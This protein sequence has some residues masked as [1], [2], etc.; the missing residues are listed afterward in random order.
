MYKTAIFDL[1][2]TLLDTLDDLTNAVNYA[3]AKH[4]LPERTAKE[5]RSFLGNGMVRLIELS[6][7]GAANT[8][9]ILAE[10]K[11]YYA[12]HSADETK[13]YEGIMEVLD[14]LKRRGVKTAILSN[15]GDFA[16]QTLTKEYFG[17]LIDEAQGE[18][19]A[20]GVKRKPSPDGVYA[21]MERLS[22][23]AEETVFIGDSEVDIR[24]AENAG[25][26]CLAVTWGFR[27][28]QEL[29]ENGGKT[30]VATPK[31]LLQFFK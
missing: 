13:P 24:T 11:S 10:F 6:A 14:A 17:D 25:V 7:N 3:L 21:I 12:V 22:A 29:I 4:G 30:L 23:K 31:E 5:I 28:K 19:E 27:D 15:K 16:V 2:G 20:Q 8:Q 26:D 1:D 18:N 9:E